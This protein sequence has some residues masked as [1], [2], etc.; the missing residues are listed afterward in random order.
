MFFSLVCHL[1]TASL[2][3]PPP[4]SRQGQRFQQ[5]LQ[6]ALRFL[7]TTCAASSSLWPYV[8]PAGPCWQAGGLWGCLSALSVGGWEAARLPKSTLHWQAKPHGSPPATPESHWSGLRDRA[9]SSSPSQLP[10][11][12]AY[13]LFYVKHIEVDIWLMC[14]WGC[15]APSPY[16]IHASVWSSFE[17]WFS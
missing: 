11:A 4:H 10:G 8:M 12:S 9:P 2:W 13:K 6:R 16:L 3:Q 5:H 15:W 14:D 17:L 1:E 7:T